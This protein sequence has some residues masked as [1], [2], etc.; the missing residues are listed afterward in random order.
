MRLEVIDTDHLQEGIAPARFTTELLANDTANHSGLRRALLLG[1]EAKSIVEVFVDHDL[2]PFHPPQLTSPTLQ[3]HQL[4]AALLTSVC[5]RM[6]TSMEGGCVRAGGHEREK[7]RHHGVPAADYSA[8][9]S[10]AKRDFLR[11]AVLA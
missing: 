9:V 2:E 11:A 1:L 7:S 5:T 3:L 10:V 6:W 4:A 8:V